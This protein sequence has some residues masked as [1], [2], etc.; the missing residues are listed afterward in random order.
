MDFRCTVSFSL[1]RGKYYD[2]TF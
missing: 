1:L 2:N